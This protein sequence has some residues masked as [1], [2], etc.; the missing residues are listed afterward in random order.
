[1]GSDSA[2]YILL[3]ALL[4]L[5]GAVMGLVSHFIR[6]S[7]GGSADDTAENPYIAAVTP[8]NALNHYFEKNIIKAEWLDNG[9]W[10]GD[11]FRNMT[12][13]AVMGA[14]APL[15]IGLSGWPHRH[16]LLAKTCGSIVQFWH[17]L[18]CQ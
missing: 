15:F 1:M 9:C 3:A 13:M 10:D 2:N 8:G 5:L 17:P 4:T 11:S 12:Y 14:A 7:F 6:A 16:E 18:F